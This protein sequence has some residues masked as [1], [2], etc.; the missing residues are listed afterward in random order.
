MRS[1]EN[2]LKSDAQA[3]KKDVDTDVLKNIIQNI[4]KQDVLMANDQIKLPIHHWQIPTGFALLA[5]LI[6]SFNVYQPTTVG[7]IETENN[8][9]QINN[10]GNVTI[11]DTMRNLQTGLL[12]QLLESRL[13]DYIKLEQRALQQDLIYLKSLF[14]L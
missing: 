8:V 6:V 13:T 7:K 10:Q 11:T 12:P 5:L 4:K 2:K 9:L 3:F 14:V 1:I